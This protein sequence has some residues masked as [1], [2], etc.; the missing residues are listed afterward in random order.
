MK[1]QQAWYIVDWFARYEVTIKG[2]AAGADVPLADL[3]QGHH[4]YVRQK[5][6][7]RHKGQGY[8]RLAQVART[9]ARLEACMCV[10]PKLLE[11]AADDEPGLRG[12]IVD[13]QGS[14]ATIEDLAFFTGFRPKT[15]ETALEILSDPRIQWLGTAEYDPLAGPPRHTPGSAGSAGNASKSGIPSDSYTETETES[16][17]DIDTDTETRGGGAPSEQEAGNPEELAPGGHSEGSGGVGHSDSDSR[18]SG[19]PPPPR[20]GPPDP[21]AVAQTLMLALRIT[22]TSRSEKQ[23]AADVTCFDKI[24]GFVATGAIGPP[25]K[26]RAMCEEWAAEAMR[27]ANDPVKWFMSKFKK[28][29]GANGNEW[30]NGKS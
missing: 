4:R 3:K 5:V 15:I 30:N 6:N 12:W 8:Q 26:A 20:A 11:I 23:Y 24:G 19:G 27:K 29:L 10:F 25:A 16:N 9:V 7:G 18:R 28:Q 22:R 14:P 17:I 2:N 1:A 21:R 13:E